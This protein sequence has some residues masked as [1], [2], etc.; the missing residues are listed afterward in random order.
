M[1]KDKGKTVP[2]AP[3]LKDVVIPGPDRPLIPRTRGYQTA[4]D[5]GH[6]GRFWRPTSTAVK[7][8]FTP[9]FRRWLR[10]GLPPSYKPNYGMEGMDT[11][12]EDLVGNAL[13]VN[14]PLV[15]FHLSKLGGDVASRLRR[16]YGTGLAEFEDTIPPTTFSYLMLLMKKYGAQ[17]SVKNPGKSGM[18][19]RVDVKVT[20]IRVL[21]NILHG[22][23][24]DG[25]NYLVK[26]HYDRER[27]P[28][29]E[30]VSH[31]RGKSVVI[32]NETRPFEMNYNSRKGQIK[33]QFYR[34]TYDRNGL[35]QNTMPGM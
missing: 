2:S 10:D 18:Y 4:R 34:Q 35:A 29:D 8:Y 11:K 22:A 32:A 20:D 14:G 24:T 3:G 12:I 5:P 27:T 6:T 17:V 15:D 19:G 16:N 1:P 9:L 33:V 26:L 7:L 28:S 25:R 23:R 31:Y 13:Q 30:T 21:R